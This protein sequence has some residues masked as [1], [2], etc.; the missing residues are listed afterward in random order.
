MLW[1]CKWPDRA[2][3]V[4]GPCSRERAVTI[5]TETAD[6]DGAPS[7]VIAFAEG[8]FRAEVVDGPG[9]DDHVEVEVDEGTLFILDEYEDAEDV[10]PCASEA[11]DA[12][13]NPVRCALG[14]PHE[15]RDHE[16]GELVWS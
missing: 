3:L 2:S 13:G 16:N 15:G 4:V 5:A 9:E 1:F 11:D 8:V 10:V 12:D 6:G 7:S 14:H